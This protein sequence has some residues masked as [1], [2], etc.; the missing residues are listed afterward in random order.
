MYNIANE[1]DQYYDFAATSYTDMS[2]YL[3][4]FNW[5][6]VLDVDDVDIAVGYFSYM[7]LLSSN[8]I[9]GIWI[10]SVVI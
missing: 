6:V 7:F 9:K 10:G 4:S 3:S 1:F 5:N 2:A 8:H